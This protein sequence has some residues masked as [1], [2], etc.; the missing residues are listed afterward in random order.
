[1]PLTYLRKDVTLASPFTVSE[2]PH[3]AKLDQ[4]E[5]PFDLP[6][7]I[8][9]FFNEKLLEFAWNRYPQPAMYYD[10]KDAF[11]EAINMKP[12]NIFL[13]AGCDQLFQFIY[14]IAGGYGRKALIFEPTY[15]MIPHAGRF[16]QTDL[17]IVNLGAEK[18]VT[19][20][21]VT[22][23]DHDIIFIVAPNNPTGHFPEEGTIEEALKRDSLVFVDE[24]YYDFS[25]RTWVHL[26]DQSPNLFIARSLSKSCLAGMRLGYGF[27]HKDVIRVLESTFTVPYHLNIMQL[28][29]IK[30]FD[31]ILPHLKA[32]SSRIARERERI[33]LK[34]EEMGISY[35]PSHGN[36]ILFKV[37]DPSNVFQ[38]LAESGVRIRSL[39]LI[40]GLAGYVRVT[41][42][43]KD[44]NDLFLE[45][46]T[47]VC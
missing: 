47:T 41:I 22:H 4:N 32:L 36:F 6:E 21:H 25:K 15:P 14:F 35:I 13:A 46:L 40:P 3:K 5:A 44:E 23:S 8:K 18:T 43:N 30:H 1:M 10:A 20:S 38:K 42:G 33:S 19:P 34:F 9:A 7:E 2:L 45:K 26:L 12:E 27:G 16:S 17:T 39:H 11:A 28:L 24:A 37:N 31:I 29:V